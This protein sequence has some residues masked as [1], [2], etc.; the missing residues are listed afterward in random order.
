MGRRSSSGVRFCAGSC[1]SFSRLNSRAHVLSALAKP[2]VKGPH[3]TCNLRL[4]TPPS[5]YRKL[6]HPLTSNRFKTCQL[7]MK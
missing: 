4:F 5:T 6:F 7:H 3:L 2:K 1:F